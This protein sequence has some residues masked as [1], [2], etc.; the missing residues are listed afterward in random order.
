MVEL[1]KVT[2][3]RCGKEVSMDEAR[4]SDNKT[5]LCLA[6][7]NKRHPDRK[8]QP[9]LIKHASRPGLKEDI[10]QEQPTEYIK[11]EC[12]NCGYKFTMKKET[13]RAKRCPYCSSDRIQKAKEPEELLKDLIDEASDRRYDY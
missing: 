7:F 5:M 1:R 2:C 11:Y 13:V 9:D 8:V 12:L 6:C 3:R 10:K 4:Y